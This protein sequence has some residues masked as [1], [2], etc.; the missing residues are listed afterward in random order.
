MRLNLEALWYA[1][2]AGVAVFSIVL[3]PALLWM[4][5][6]ETDDGE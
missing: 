4:I 5:W 2:T 1:I 3:T 6:R